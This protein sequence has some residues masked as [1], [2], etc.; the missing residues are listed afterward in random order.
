MILHLI[1]KLCKF[2]LSCHNQLFWHIQIRQGILM[3]LNMIIQH[4]FLH[5]IRLRICLYNTKNH[6][7]NLNQEVSYKVLICNLHSIQHLNILSSH[8]LNHEE[9]EESWPLIRLNHRNKYHRHKH[10]SQQKRLFLKNR[11]NSII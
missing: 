9:R 7:N 1:L 3:C 8:H 10:R 5:R 11:D 2:L 6:C 4:N